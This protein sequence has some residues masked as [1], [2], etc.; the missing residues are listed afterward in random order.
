MKALMFGGLASVPLLVLVEGGR[1]GVDGWT[2]AACG[3]M[4]LAVVGLVCSWVA[5]ADRKLS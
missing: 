1:F 5:S 4:L 3:I 2:R